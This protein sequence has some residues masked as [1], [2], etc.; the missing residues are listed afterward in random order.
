VISPFTKAGAVVHHRYDFLSEVRSSERILGKDPV[1]LNDAVAEP[2]YDV[3]TASPGNAAPY[4]AVVPQQSRLQVNAADAPDAALSASLDFSA[5]DQVP[6]RI[7]DRI[8]WHAV[9]GQD[10]TPPAPGPNAEDESETP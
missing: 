4:N 1:G 3:F 5:I 9:F 6:Q 10:S 7:L 8:V 2:M